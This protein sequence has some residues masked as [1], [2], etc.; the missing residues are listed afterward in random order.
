[1]MRHYYKE[2]G[3]IMTMSELM[4]PRFTVDPAMIVSDLTSLLT[5]NR[6]AINRLSQQED[7]SWQTLVAP[8][9]DL[10]DT[11]NQFWS[12]IS[13]LHA[14]MDNPKL[15]GAYTACLPL[16]SDYAADIGQHK[17]LFLAY[18]KIKNSSEF[19][20]LD[21]AK[22]ATILYALR[23]FRLSGV[24]LTNEKQQRYKALG[25]TLSSL[26][27]TFSNNVLDVT[28]KWQHSITDETELAGLPEQRKAA[29]KGAAA[30][31]TQSGWLLTLDYP[32]YHDVMTYANSRALRETFYHAFNTRAS[33]QGPHNNEHDNSAVM[34]RILASRHELA[35]LLG[36]SEY[37][38]LSLEPKMAV[39]SQ[40]V[41][42][43]LNNIL[44]EIKPKA[45]AELAALKA[46]AQKDN[47]DLQPW[48]VAYYSEKL[49]QANYAV[50]AE[51]IRAYFPVDTVLQ[52]L[53]NI[54]S[55]L[56]GIVLKPFTTETWHC[57]VRCYQLY[58]EKGALIGAIYL[59]LYARENK[60]GGAW[61]DE[62]VCRREKLNGDIQLPVALLTCNFAPGTETQSALL[63]HQDVITLFHEMGH[64]LQHL[65]TQVDVLDVSGINNVPWDA[66]EFPSQFFEAWCW[67][68][69][70][71]QLLSSHH[72]TGEPLP[73]TLIEK[74]IA[75]KNFQAALFLIRQIEFALFDMHLH[76]H[77]V[78]DTDYIETTIKQVREAVAVM[79]VPEYHRFA[80]SFSHIFAG[81]YAAGYYSYLWAEV[82]ARDAFSLFKVGGIFNRA[83]G[84]KFKSTV[85]AEGGSQ[86]PERLFEQLMGRKPDN[87]ALLAYYGL[88]PE[89]RA[90]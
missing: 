31:K 29:A 74:L 5:H 38:D 89:E 4:L 37:A 35:G 58:N 78:D 30:Q 64:C 3:Q 50:N 45:I 86:S 76:T 65:L 7:P 27:T 66:V 34:Q 80:H 49:R 69:E 42:T 79:S 61:M 32:C 22:Q 20:K 36:F 10:E 90:A 11:L 75:A 40:Q 19:K 62:L 60:R 84:E 14:V 85:L 46:F 48:D 24:T 6:E 54:I 53:F 43:F 77:Y 15:R 2:D 52:G 87:A 70:S 12:P 1:M 25:S 57:D 18:K 39:S 81:G 63:T 71:L 88:S 51:E 17:G 21:H 16:L 8:L 73:N 67:Q 55:N 26:T 9:D 68:S 23:D 72:E 28:Q 41:V 82:L 33:D 13:H 56:Y 59:D 47:I 83:L 44:T